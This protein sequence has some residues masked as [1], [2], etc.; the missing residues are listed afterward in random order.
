MRRGNTRHVPVNG[1]LKLYH[2]LIGKEFRLRLNLLYFTYGQAK[3]SL[4]VI[5]YLNVAHVH[6]FYRDENNL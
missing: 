4:L 3:K 6:V 5:V 1:T 2:L